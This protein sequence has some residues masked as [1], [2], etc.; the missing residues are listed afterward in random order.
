VAAEASLTLD[1]TERHGFEYQNWFGFTLYADS[2]IGALGRGGSYEIA[3]ADGG[4]EAAVGF[5]LYPDP[6]TSAGFGAKTRDQIFLPL[7]HDRQ[8]AAGLRQAGW[9]TVA[10]L[11]EKDQAQELGCSHILNGDQPEPL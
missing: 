1:P 5:S 10:A 3:L 9:R 11:S 8:A 4:S 2:F 6:L 7:G